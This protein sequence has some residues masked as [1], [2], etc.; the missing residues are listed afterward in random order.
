MVRTHHEDAKDDTERMALLASHPGWIVAFHASGTNRA[1]RPASNEQLLEA[2]NLA[3]WSTWFALPGLGTHRGTRPGALV[4]GELVTGRHLRL[5]RLSAPES[6]VRAPSA[7]RMVPRSVRALAAAPLDGA[8]TAWLDLC[9][10]PAVKLRCSALVVQ[11]G[12]SLSPTRRHRT[13]L[14]ALWNPLRPFTRTATVLTGDGRQIRG[15]CA[16][17]PPTCPAPL[18]QRSAVTAS[19]VDVPCSRLGALRRPPKHVG[20][21]PR[22]MCRAA[23]LQRQ[24]LD[25]VIETTRPAASSRVRDLFPARGRNSEHCGWVLESGAVSLL[26]SAAALREVA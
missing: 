11:R 2:D 14:S 17:T 10:G 9:A 25:A 21:S 3:P 13:A 24:L 19:P 4:D 5:R 15:P 23:A 6:Y 22:A 1:W 16:G 7:P 26:D 20:A 18:T 12:A 8:D